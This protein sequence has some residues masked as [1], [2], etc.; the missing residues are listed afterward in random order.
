VRFLQTE[1]TEGVLIFVK[2]RNATNVVSENLTQNGFIATAL[3]GD[4]AQNQRER[5]VSQLKSGKINVVVATDVAARGLDV[6]RI[7][8]VINYDFPHDTESYVHRIGRTG[9]AG[10][11]GNAVLFVEPKEKGKLSRLQRATN[12]R[13][14]TFKQKSL[15]EIN[16]I[17]IGKFKHR[18]TEAVESKQIDFFTSIIQDL[19]N[20]SEMPMEKI[21]AA[22]AIVAQG[23]TPLMLEALKSPK[24]NWKKDR[25]K[26]GRG[27]RDTGPMQTYRVEVG[28]SD[29]VGPGNLVGAIT[30]EAN[31]T[32][33]DIGRI[34]LFDKFST[35][36]LPADLPEDMVTHLAGLFVSGQ[37]LQL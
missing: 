25:E 34:K 29:G 2:T 11:S 22:L 9:R 26:S 28:R 3:N 32:N 10:R 27:P 17:R 1:E 37:Q 7:S 24:S 4:V 31:L 12:Q 8:H 18:I 16:N 13:I 33:A 14:D 15:E 36:D 6:P 19:A 5:T 23:D 30:N 21:A 35:I 20:E